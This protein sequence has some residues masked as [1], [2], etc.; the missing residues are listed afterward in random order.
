[1]RRL[2]FFRVLLPAALIV[3]LAVLYISL[4]ERPTVHGIPAGDAFQTE[5]SATGVRAVQLVGEE[6]G[7]EFE[8][9]VVEPRADGGYHLEMIDRLAIPRE[10]KGPL[11]IQAKGA[12]IDGPEQGRKIVVQ[13]EVVV[14]DPED[15]LTLRLPRLEIDEVAGVARSKG[16]I[17]FEGA[18]SSGS[19]SELIY[20][21]NGQPS[22]LFDPVLDDASGMSVRADKAVLLDGLDD[23]ELR[24]AVE[25]TR[26]EELFLT[27][28]LRLKRDEES[29][30]RHAIAKGAVSGKVMLALDAPSSMS[31]DRVEVDWDELG[32]TEHVLLHGHAHLARAEQSLS[33]SRIEAR[34]DPE[35]RRWKVQARGTVFAQGRFGDGPAWMR[36]ESFTAIM[37]HQMQPISAEAQ[38]RVRFEAPNTRAEADRAEF[39]P[40]GL[41]ARIRLFAA[42]NRKA[43]LS[44]ERTRIAAETITTD[45]R[46]IDLVA[47]G[48]VEAT[49]MPAGEEDPNAE[50]GGLFQTSEAIHFVAAYLHGQNSGD[51]LVFRES[52]R[53][54]QGERNL[55]ADEIELRKGDQGLSATGNVTT[56]VPRAMGS[57]ALGEADYVQISADNL[58]YDGTERIAVY[59]DNVRVAILEGWLEA[60]RVEILL[61]D[62]DGSGIREIRAQDNVRI[63]FSD[64]DADDAPQ[65]VGGTADRAIYLPADRTIRLF[66]D[67]KPAMVRRLG[68][69]GA[70]TSGRVLRYQLDEGSLEVE[71]GE[72]TPA[73]IRGR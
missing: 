6:Q 36:S 30:L 72:Q 45:Q 5:R 67:A 66:G 70:T 37:D 73:R 47:E 7:V 62:G 8:A 59:H 39:E 20:G 33:S 9:Q 57:D 2:R 26:G 60:D 69:Q 11:V 65:M 12:D 23:L 49:L 4:R 68:S 43:R 40:A 51:R 56:R 52:V 31:A 10:G 29:R 24:G 16:E 41:V 27:D 1:L 19:A 48:R 42:G 53:A 64:P 50:V 32:E 58:V 34:L 3:F 22:E 54:W 18:G 17:I 61:A 25:A 13:E 63:E 44:L 15:G 71:S 28:N 38:G 55:S 46:G 14:T 21:L 35:L